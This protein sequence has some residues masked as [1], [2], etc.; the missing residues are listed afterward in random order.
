MKVLIV[1]PRKYPRQAEIAPSLKAMQE[2]VGG[3]IQA[4]YPFSEEVALVCN[5]EGKLLGLP[6]NRALRGEDGW[7][8]DVICG[9]FFLCAAPGDSDDF[10]GLTQEQAERYEERFHTPEAFI[11][12]KHG[13]VLCVPMEELSQ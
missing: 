11:K 3:C 5:D 6:M 1:E 13:D 10:A 8:Y 9:T 12:M 2:I 4:T 7:P